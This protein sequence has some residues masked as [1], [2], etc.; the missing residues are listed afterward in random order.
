MTTTLYPDAHHYVQGIARR[1]IQATDEDLES[2]GH[3][4]CHHDPEGECYS[5]LDWSPP[6][7]HTAKQ[8]AA[9]EEQ[10]GTG[11][12]HDEPPDH[13]VAAAEAEAQTWRARRRAPTR[14]FAEPEPPTDDEPAPEPAAA[15][16]DEP[17]PRRRRPASTEPSEAP[18]AIP[19]DDPVT[20]TSEE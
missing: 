15:T 14:N 12:Y 10:L 1:P 2:R 16:D 18:G 8:M 5:P 3:D 13:I 20:T 9:Y 19:T 6:I 7:F 17:A 11:H 4:E